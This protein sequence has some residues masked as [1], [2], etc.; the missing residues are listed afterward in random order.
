MQNSFS[1][2]KIQKANDKKKYCHFYSKK[3]EIQ[4]TIETLIDSR[5][6]NMLLVEMTEKS[7][8]RKTLLN[9]FPQIGHVPTMFHALGI[10]LLIAETI[11]NLN[12]SW[13]IYSMSIFKKDSFSIVVC[14]QHLF[15]FVQVPV[16]L[17]WNW[18]WHIFQSIKKKVTDKWCSF[19]GFY[20]YNFTRKQRE[21]W[22]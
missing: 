14:F 19:S 10:V 1:I 13:E 16:S 5:L 22:Q 8:Q 11:Q 20:M 2:F 3:T 15:T 17:K 21:L 7:I 6:N 12:I 18:H 9:W 4:W